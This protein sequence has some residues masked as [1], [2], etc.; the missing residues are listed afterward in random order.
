[1]YIQ[2][3]HLES[4]DYILV[5]VCVCVCVCVHIYMYMSY[6]NEYYFVIY[7]LSLFVFFLNHFWIKVDKNINTF[8]SLSKCIT[9]RW[10]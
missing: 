4:I 3:I 5:C 8:E 7:R 9:V 10:L 6:F 1:M 2:S